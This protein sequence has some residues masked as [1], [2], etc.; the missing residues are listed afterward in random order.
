MCSLDKGTRAKNIAKA[1][2]SRGQASKKV[3][4]PSDGKKSK[5][6]SEPLKE[7]P[8]DI[9]E[10]SSTSLPESCVLKS[11]DYKMKEEKKENYDES[12]ESDEDE[13]WEE[14]EGGCVSV[15]V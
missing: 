10:D 8:E 4:K 1:T 13:D 12:E 3:Q 7:E 2:K 6:F 9:F 15:K 5:Y 11:N 14:V